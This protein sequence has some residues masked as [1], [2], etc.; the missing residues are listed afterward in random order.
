[1]NTT[2]EDFLWSQ[3]Y[4]PNTVADCILPPQLKATFQQFVDDQFIPTLLLAG[5]PGIG[6]TSVAVAMVKELNSDYIMINGSL[7]GNIDTLRTDILNF[8]SSVSLNGG[9]KYVILDEA[10]HLNPNSFQPALR[11][12]ME[13]FSK[14]CGFILTCNYK[15]R[16]IDALHSRC[17]VVEFK[18]ENSD[19]PAIA[20]Q[21]F[22]RIC[23][24]LDEQNVKYE[25]A[26]VAEVVKKYLPDWRRTINELQRHAAT[27]A[28]DKKILL[29]TSEENIKIL[30][31]H[32]AAK[33]FNDVRKWIGENADIDT[34]SLYRHLYDS[35]DKIVQ[36]SSVPQLVTILAEYQYKASRVADAEIN[37]V[38]CMVEIMASVQFK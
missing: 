30:V 27:G 29:D 18:L 20:Q 32:L 35:A 23:R 1:M 24:I 15:N 25:R 34:A 2:P 12:F 22:N 17:A 26:V 13:E 36:P 10:D 33:R 14:N 19:K 8:A 4:R 3:L 16:I 5:R 6:K 37:N 28:I 38:A 21:F 11:N 31:G 7:Y 9:R